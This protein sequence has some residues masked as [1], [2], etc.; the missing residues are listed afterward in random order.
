[1]SGGMIL[2]G[3]TAA[4]V[5]EM[6]GSALHR[7][8]ARTL[9]ILGVSPAGLVLKPGERSAD[10]NSANLEPHH[11]NFIMVPAA[12]WGGETSTMFC[13]ANALARRVPAVAVLANGG[14]ISKKEILNA[15]RHRIPVVVIEGSGRLADQIARAMHRRD[16]TPPEEWASV[17][18][19]L[20]PDGDILEILTDGDLRLFSVAGQGDALRL[21]LLDILQAQRDKLLL[22]QLEAGAMG[23]GGSGSGEG[24]SDGGRAS[25][26]A[27][28]H[29]SG[30]DLPVR[31]AGPSKQALNM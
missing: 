11:P 25:L 28:S 15:V 14:M 29:G 12:E 8:D 9:R 13:F 19:F 31:P 18:G 1:M 16:E 7:L 2:D 27:S 4:G 26:G 10:P 6:V 17:K 30:G 3:G 20:V 22:A 5:M 23:S 24:G 21:V